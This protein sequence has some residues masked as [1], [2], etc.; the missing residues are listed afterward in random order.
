LDIS[1]A[2]VFTKAFPK[3]KHDICCH[4]IGLRHSIE[5]FST[6]SLREGV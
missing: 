3:P 6:F 2:N 1:W 4:A 5:Q